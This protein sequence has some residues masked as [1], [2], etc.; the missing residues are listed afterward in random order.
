MRES[1]TIDAAEKLALAARNVQRAPMSGETGLKRRMWRGG[2]AGA[3]RV[4]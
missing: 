3:S 4:I 2:T 1:R